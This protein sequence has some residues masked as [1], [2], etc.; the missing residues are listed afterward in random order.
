MSE[1]LSGVGTEVTT[2]ATSNDAPIQEQ[3]A[4]ST[5]AEPEATQQAA[6]TP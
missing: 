2:D 6:E 1:G 5:A 3:A 4:E